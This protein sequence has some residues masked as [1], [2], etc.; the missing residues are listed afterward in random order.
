VIR[1]R[2]SNQRGMTTLDWLNSY[3]T[4]S[5][6]DYRD[7]RFKHFR[8]LRV[9]NEDWIRPNTGF[10]KHG[11]Q[12]MEIITYV[13][14]GSLTHEDSMG[15]HFQIKAGEFQRMSA[16]SGIMHSEVNESPREE[17]HLI[18]IW[19]FPET[20]ELS[21]SYEQKSFSDAK[22]QAFLKVVSNHPVHGE[23]KI[24]QDAE[25]YVGRFK[26]EKVVFKARFERFFGSKCFKVS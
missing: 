4:F 17:V 1:L 10:G 18:Q 21:P 11:H 15:H 12:N 2:P 8:A 16:G 3:H 24:H 7:E 5:F 14:K 22:K 25:L 9:I 23:L 19:I 26:N 6:G 20:N 13:L